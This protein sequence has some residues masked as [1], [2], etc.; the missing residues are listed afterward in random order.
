MLETRRSFLPHTR[1]LSLLSVQ[2]GLGGLCLDA[3]TVYVFN[4]ALL[5]FRTWHSPSAGHTLLYLTSHIGIG[6]L[7]LGLMFVQQALG[8]LSLKA[9]QSMHGCLASPGP[10]LQ[11]SEAHP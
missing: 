9:V 10:S 6:V 11:D 3:G 2:P 8:L 1:C 5:C 4:E 7:G